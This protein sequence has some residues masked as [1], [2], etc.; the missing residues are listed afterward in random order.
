MKGD[1]M[2]TI[3]GLDI[4]IASVGVAVVDKDSLDI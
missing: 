2:G 4:G 3:I 1:N